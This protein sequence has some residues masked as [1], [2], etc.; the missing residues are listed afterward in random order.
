MH[1][2]FIKDDFAPNGRGSYYVGE[3]GQHNVERLVHVMVQDFMDRLNPERVIF[4]GSSKGGYGSIN[5]GIEFENAVII[6]GAPQYRLG[7]YL[8]K[9][10]NR[11]NLIDII[12][13]YTQENIAKLDARLEGKIKQNPFAKTQTCYLHYSNVEHTYE[14]HIRALRQDLIDSGIQLYEDIEGYPEHGDVGKYYPAFLVKTVNEII[15][16]I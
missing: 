9:P 1:R 13:D 15:D 12:G 10:A 16:Q 3:K 7:T 4:M 14:K 2:L 8:D 11:P 5:C 6:A